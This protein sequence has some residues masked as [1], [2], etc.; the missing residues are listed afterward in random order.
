LPLNKSEKIFWIGF[1]SLLVVICAVFLAAPGWTYRPPPP[2]KSDMGDMPGMSMGDMA[3]MPGMNHET[4]VEETPAQKAKHLAD[5]RESEFNHHFAGVLV[6]LAALFFLA[7][8][9]LTKRWRAARYAWPMCFLIAGI[10]LLVFSDTEIWPFGFM[11][12]IYAITHNPEDAQH[13]TF[14]LILLVLGVVEMLRASGRLKAAWSAW[15]FPVVSLAG[16]ILLLFHHHGGMHGPDAM[17]T[18]VTVQ[19]E[20]LHFAEA[21]VGAAVA[22][23]LAESSAK[24]YDVFNKVW[25]VFLIVLGVMLVMYSE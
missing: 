13:K 24:W 14:A 1:C 3:D 21:G 7:Q 12:F 23:G 9:S 18:M 16:C 17:K 20:H 25:P 19:H 2:P 11:S 8:P 10:F 22:K 6:I 5:K 15:V 4:A